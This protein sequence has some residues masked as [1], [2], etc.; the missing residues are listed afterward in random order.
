MRPKR[1]AILPIVVDSPRD[2]E[3]VDRGELFRGLDRCRGHTKG[4]EDVDVLP[5]VPLQGKDA[6]VGHLTILARRG[7]P[8]P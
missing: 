4:L 6:D 8:Y 7:A 3:R 1:T 2:H 5:D